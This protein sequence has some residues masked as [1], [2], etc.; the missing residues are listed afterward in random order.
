MEQILAN[1]FILTSRYVLIASGISLIYKYSKVL[2]FSQAAIIIVGAYGSL[3]F[4]EFLRIPLP[5]AI[6]F[7]GLMGGLIGGIID[8]VIY[9]H[10]RR[11]SNPNLP[12]LLASLG[13]LIFTENLFS[14]IFGD[15]SW[16]LSWENPSPGFLIFGARITSIQI[17]SIG[18]AIIIT[19]FVWF[20]LYSNKLGLMLRSMGSNHDLAIILGL[21]ET[22]LFFLGSAFG[23]FISA[24]AG[25]LIALETDITPQIG[26]EAILIGILIALLSSE[27]KVMRIVLIAFCIACIEVFIGTY[28]SFLWRE[29]LTF[30]IVFFLIIA[31]N[32]ELLL[33]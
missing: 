33:N 17:A 30:I 23:S 1:S 5:I 2:D 29:V 27:G 28:V 12:I 14:L 20:L 7:S 32:N 4:N 22:K 6:I 13:L 10:I 15:I 24:I 31:Q 25:S 3:I 9:K 11:Y 16:S 26:N 19:A 18:I 21:S 8:F